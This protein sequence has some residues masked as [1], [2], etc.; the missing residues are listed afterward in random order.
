MH[1]SRIF[2]LCALPLLIAL[3][4]GPSCLGRDVPCREAVPLADQTDHLPTCVGAPLETTYFTLNP[5]DSRSGELREQSRAEWQRRLKDH[6]HFPSLAPLGPLDPSK[7]LL[8]LVPG[9]GMNFQDAH[10][11]ITLADQYQIVLAVTDQRQRMDRIGSELATAVEGFLLHRRALGQAQGIEVSTRLRIIGHSYGVNLS[12]LMLGH[13]IERG[14]LEEGSDT[15][16]GEVLHVLLDGAWRGLDLPWVFTLPVLKQ[17]LG[18]ALPV[19][20]LHK[21]HD[22]AM[23]VANGT[24]GMNRLNTIVLPPSVT[25]QIAAVESPDGEGPAKQYG[26]VEAVESWLPG[27]L[28][29]DRGELERV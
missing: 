20:T 12:R 6:R 26:Q 15:L 16:I 9:F 5:D 1:L 23:T 13:L 22:G 25:V 21:L 24:D 19:L 10:A 18:R 28:D 8:L 4:S 17:L 11:L 3:A 14:L 7:E 2:I 29:V 27:E